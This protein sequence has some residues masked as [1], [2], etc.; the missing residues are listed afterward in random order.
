MIGYLKIRVP[1]TF[2]AGKFP[3]LHALALH[4]ETRDEF[5]KARPAA[6]ESVPARS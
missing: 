5:V 1:D 3:K 6:N 2:P 4:C